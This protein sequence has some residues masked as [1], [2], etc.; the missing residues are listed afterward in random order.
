MKQLNPDEQDLLLQSLL[1]ELPLKKAKSTLFID[2][3]LRSDPKEQLVAWHRFAHKG[4]AATP[5]I[6]KGPFERIYLRIPQERETIGML[7]HASA[8][9]LA[10]TG[11]ILIY[12]MNDEGM[13]SVSD[14]LE[15]LFEEV[16]TL[17]T[18]RHARIVRAAHWKKEIALKGTLADWG[19]TVNLG[20]GAEALSLVSYPGTFAHGHIDP[21]TRFLLQH[22]PTITP[23][24]RVLDFGAGIG[25][26]AA[27]LEKRAPGVVID[28]VDVNAVAIE[29][30]KQN[31]PQ[32]RTFVCDG[33]N[34]V[35][36]NTYDF[37]ISNPPVHLK[38]A[39]TLTLIT[40]LLEQGKKLLSLYGEIHFVVQ[41]TI[42]IKSLLKTLDFNGHEVASDGTYTIWRARNHTSV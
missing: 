10:P 6:P 8:S 37:I 24:S 26:L 33:L 15:N 35:K 31:V 28:L 2:P 20:S 22:L 25:T 30:A 7:C 40:T 41:G 14:K 5:W 12:G 17:L 23:T 32:A 11:E 13:R 39:Q 4:Q 36:G 27:V 1:E 34:A 19:V 42:P 9:Q 21:G 16:E 29:A 18:K 3:G 38:R